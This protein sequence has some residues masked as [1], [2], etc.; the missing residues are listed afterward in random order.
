M[1]LLKLLKFKKTPIESVDNSSQIPSADKPTPASYETAVQM[2]YLLN[3]ARREI[4][5]FLSGQRFVNN[6]HL[7]RLLQNVDEVSDQALAG[8]KRFEDYVEALETW[9]QAIFESHPRKIDPFPD[10]WL[11]KYSEDELERIAIMTVDGCKTD[12]EAVQFIEYN[13]GTK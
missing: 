13:R 5:A 11:K 8:T 12:A 3:V 2:A 7:R 1:A 6:D 9:K 10:D 4:E